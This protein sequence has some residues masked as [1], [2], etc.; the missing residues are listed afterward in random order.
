M[1]RRLLVPLTLLCVL[2]APTVADAARQQ[3]STFQDDN[4]LVYATPGDAAHTL[5]TLKA[6][7]VDRVRISVFWREVAPA[8]LSNDKPNFDASDPAQYPPGSWDRYDTLVRLAQQRGLGV[9]FN[10]TAPGPYW[11]MGN[12]ERA[13]IK[14][15]YDPSA[16]EFQLFV[17]AVG[18]R[19]SGKYAPV[20]GQPPLPRVN[21][22]S[23]WNEPNQPGWLTPQYAIDP[24]DTKNY[25]EVAPR[26][27]RDLVDA[28][29]T[30]LQ[31]TGHGDDTI[32]VGETAP[33]GQKEKK[34]VTRAIPAL[35]FIRELYCVDDNLQPYQG[36]SAQLRG[37][38]VSNP[39][40]FPSAHPGLFKYTG[41]AHH[42]Y[43]LLLSPHTKPDYKDYATIANVADLQKLL[44]RVFQRYGQ[45][46]AGGAKNGIPLY[47]T[48]FGYQTPPDPQGVSFAQQAAYIN[49][50]EYIA[51]RNGNVKTLCQF[52]LNDDKPVPGVPR[53]SQDAWLTF[54][55]GIA[56]EKGAHKPS[57]DAY[58]MPIFLPKR[59]VR[60]KHRIY[61]WGGVR[62]AA[63]GKKYSVGIELKGRK[64]SDTFKRIATAQTDGKR[65]YI[66]TK[67]KI[68]RSGRIRIA[69]RNPVTKAVTYSRSVSI[70]AK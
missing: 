20:I 43:E 42:P 62:I 27:Y 54:Q 10:V 46:L 50:S 61:V 7:G 2:A 44:K 65:G 70:K 8:A 4:H 55:S 1:L 31:A 36:T 14:N 17:R 69:W 45:P 16:K 12:P 22:W 15:V 24:R 18:T 35:K 53:D 26:I 68:N 60:R 28:M 11:A 6:L 37:C 39:G 40:S 19:Y 29:W 49:E 25:I 13:D 58:E 32:L 38:P 41:Y 34:G 21:Y 66:Y 3:E 56:N 47:F 9:N 63:E 52:L 57:Y 59:S 5:D 64:R 30:A 51:W 33:K 23:V 67:V 48:E